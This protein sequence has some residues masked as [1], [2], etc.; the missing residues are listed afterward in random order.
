[1]VRGALVVA[2]V[3][4][5]SGSAHAQAHRSLVIQDADS[6]EI[7]RTEADF[8]WRNE[9]ERAQARGREELQDELGKELRGREAVLLAEQRW[10]SGLADYE[11]ATPPAAATRD[12]II[13]QQSLLV[14]LRIEAEALKVQRASAP[15]PVEHEEVTPDPPPSAA[16]YVPPTTYVVEQPKVDVIPV[17]RAEAPPP[18]PRHQRAIKSVSSHRSDPRR[19]RRRSGVCCCDGSMSP[20][21]TYVHSGCC[22][23]HGGVCGC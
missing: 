8:Y 14:D 1:M 10:L 12:W 6:A 4:L 7:L 22:S 15:Q 9:H 3:R 23:H 20:T 5:A 18:P 2:L 17:P 11:A 21:C 16:T 19:E 13:R